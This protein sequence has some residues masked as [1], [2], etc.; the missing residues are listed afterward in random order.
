MDGRRGGL[1]RIQITRLLA[2]N[3][4]AAML[5]LPMVSPHMLQVR[6]W[7]S[8]AQN[9]G[10]TRVKSFR[11]DL[12]SAIAIGVPHRYG[13]G[14]ASD[15]YPT[16]ESL[17]K[18]S[19]WNHRVV[20]RLI[21]ALMALGFL[22]LLLR[23]HASRWLVLAPAVAAVAAIAMAVWTGQFLYLRFVI[24]ALIPVVLLS[25][26][27]IESI[28]RAARRF[29]PERARPM[30][31]PLL[32]LMALIGYY[33]MTRMPRLP[34]LSRPIAPTREAATFM[35]SQAGDDPFS[36]IR[37]GYLSA[38]APAP[39][40]DPWMI[41]LRDPAQVELYSQE[42]ARQGK[43]FFICFFNN[44]AKEKKMA[45]RMQFMIDDPDFK[46]VARFDGS[47]PKWTYRVLEYSGP[48]GAE[49]V[50]IPYGNW[51]VIDHDNPDSD[52]IAAEG[53]GANRFR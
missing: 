44:P 7:S 41:L 10:I 53:D 14:D 9:E 3:A 18:D 32:L 26:I 34:L 19:R 13:K 27:G 52:E 24:Y 35:R 28:A 15:R 4:L 6:H 40:Y 33:E 38:G 25:L 36:V 45:K 46:E 12:W 51:F 43:P 48:A 30:V 16:L 39:L 2:A 50:A 47:E 17:T 5:L 37:A 8:Y 31:S 49:P 11:R 23:R 1:A 21:P 22:A 29:L 20:R 42:A